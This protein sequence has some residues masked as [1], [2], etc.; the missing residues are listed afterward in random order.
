M[1][2]PCVKNKKVVYNSVHTLIPLDIV[3]VINYI[4]VVFDI[5]VIIVIY[6][7]RTNYALK[8]GE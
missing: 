1:E 6:V 2:K 7:C 8:Y 4:D 5:G 3:V